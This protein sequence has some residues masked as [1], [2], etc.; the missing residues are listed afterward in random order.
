H[1][2]LDAAR[3]P[4]MDSMLALFATAAVVCLERALALRPRALFFI[5]AALAI[6]LGALT[7]GILGIALPGIVIAFYL[8]VRRRFG[9]LLRLDLVAALTTGLAIG[10]FWYLPACKVGGRSCL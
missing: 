10:L 1:F 6:G 2:F 5:L 7:K 4:R 3:Q 9:E 8:A